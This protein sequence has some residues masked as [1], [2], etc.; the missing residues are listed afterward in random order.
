MSKTDRPT[1]KKKAK[2]KPAKKQ[3]A[4]KPTLVKDATPEPLAVAL[5]VTRGKHRMTAPE[6]EQVSYGEREAIAVQSLEAIYR[7]LGIEP[8]AIA[9]LVNHQREQFL[10]DH[11]G[12]LVHRIAALENVIMRAQQMQAEQQ[13][14]A[15]DE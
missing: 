14:G 15:A 10:A 5:R 2:R 4:K 1:V 3:A 7:D 11:F 6:M 12:M 9:L 13:E 8:P